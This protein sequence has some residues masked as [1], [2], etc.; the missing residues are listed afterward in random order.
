MKPIVA[1]VIAAAAMV[2]LTLSTAAADSIDKYIKDLKS[3]SPGVRAKAAY[4]LGCG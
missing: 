4:E 3:D 1:R 2:V